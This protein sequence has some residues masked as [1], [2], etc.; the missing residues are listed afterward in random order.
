[1]EIKWNHK[2]TKFN[3]WQKKNHMEQIEKKGKDSR[4]KAN[5]KTIKKKP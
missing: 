2:S 5:H 4:L 1:M 3:Q